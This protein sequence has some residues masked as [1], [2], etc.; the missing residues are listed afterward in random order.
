MYKYI[1]WYLF[2][3]ASPQP[4]PSQ[5]VNHPSPN[6]NSKCV[7]APC[8]GVCVCDVNVRLGK[9]NAAGWVGLSFSPHYVKQFLATAYVKNPESK[10]TRYATNEMFYQDDQGSNRPRSIQKK[11]DRKK[12]SES[13]YGSH[14]ILPN[15]C[16]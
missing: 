5:K 9:G 2:A 8:Y 1:E 12:G 3:G 16:E 15:F 14:K 10:M 11:F 4:S 13:V 7:Q 6:S